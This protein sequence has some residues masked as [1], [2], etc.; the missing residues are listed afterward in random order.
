LNA[1]GVDILLNG[2]KL[3]VCANNNSKLMNL[4]VDYN[5]AL[6]KMGMNLVA[7]VSELESPSFLIL[8]FLRVS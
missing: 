3:K 4:D 1:Y 5:F 6:A 8:M 7:L 2:S